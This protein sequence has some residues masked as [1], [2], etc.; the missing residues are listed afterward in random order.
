MGL[1]KFYF[2]NFSDVMA[3]SLLLIL[4]KTKGECIMKKGKRIFGGILLAVVFIIMI[5]LFLRPYLTKDKEPESKEQLSI[6]PPK[7]LYELSEDMNIEGLL[8][9]VSEAELTEDYEKIDSYYKKRG[10]LQSRE[11]YVKE[12]IEQFADRDLFVGDIRYFRVKC[13]VTNTSDTPY[14]FSPSSL[15]PTSIIGNDMVGWYFN[16]YDVRM[17]SGGNDSFKIE[18]YKQKIGE[19][20]VTKY[21]DIL[22]KESIELELVGE[23]CLN[24]IYSTYGLQFS[25]SKN[26]KYELYL[27]GENSTKKIHLNISGEFGENKIYQEARNIQE[28]KAQSWTNLE[29]MAWHRE[30]REKNKIEHGYRLDEESRPII[31]TEEPGQEFLELLNAGVSNEEVHSAF[32]LVTTLNDFKIT[33]WKDMPSD[34]AEQGTLKKMAERYEDIYNCHEEELK[35]LVLDLSYTSSELGQIVMD[36]YRRAINYFYGRSKL[37]VKDEKNELWLFG[38]ADSWIVTENSAHPENVGSVNLDIMELDAGISVRM[39]YILPPQLYEEYSAL[40]F[41]GG[42]YELTYDEEQVPMTKIELNI[43]HQQVD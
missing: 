25:N 16:N 31:E 22:P 3:G 29:Q 12:Y 35:V 37:Y 4:I 5:V 24:D 21:Y 15:A 26:S 13:L 9:N 30:W 34:F 14:K 40:Y 39:A 20:I 2:G 36:V 38:G 10:F 33:E 23:L 6:K 19:P 43:A 41:T 42:R 1:L 18:G 27:V 17:I 32:S 28:M 11:E 8:W 7:Q